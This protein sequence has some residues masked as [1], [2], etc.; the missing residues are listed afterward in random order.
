MDSS[1]PP[2]RPSTCAYATQLTPRRPG[3]YNPRTPSLT[4]EQARMMVQEEFGSDGHQPSPMAAPSGISSQ[5]QLPDQGTARTSPTFHTAPEEIDAASVESPSKRR[6]L[7][8]KGKAKE[9]PLDFDCETN[10]FSSSTR[11]SNMPILNWMGRAATEPQLG[12]RAP[13]HQQSNTLLTENEILRQLLSEKEKENACLRRQIKLM[14][15]LG[16][17]STNDTHMVSFTSFRGDMPSFHPRTNLAFVAPPPQLPQ[18]SSTTLN[19]TR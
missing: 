18:Q 6:R 2:P 11:T 17:M 8:S 19:R 5:I 4:A 10:F 7:D 1:S 3:P 15:K 13:G 9:I 14:K 16:R 12:H